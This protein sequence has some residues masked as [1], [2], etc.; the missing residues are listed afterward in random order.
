MQAVQ[1][2][3]NIQAA[4]FI[5]DDEYALPRCWECGNGPANCPSCSYQ[6]EIILLDYDQRADLH[7]AARQQEEPRASYTK[8]QL[9][10]ALEEFRTLLHEYAPWYDRTSRQMIHAC[11]HNLCISGGTSNKIGLAI[12]FFK[13]EYVRASEVIQA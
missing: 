6:G 3:E 5:Q 9:G 8:Q 13:E 11:Y 1:A 12:R 4:E 7:D 10:N 2:A